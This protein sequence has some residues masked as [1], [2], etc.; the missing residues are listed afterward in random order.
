MSRTRVTSE[1]STYKMGTFKTTCYW[2][3]HESTE[4]MQRQCIYRHWHVPSKSKPSKVNSMEE[5]RNGHM[6]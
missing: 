2:E 6:Q 1:I 5:D 4:A 3:C